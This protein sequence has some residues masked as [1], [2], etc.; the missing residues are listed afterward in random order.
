M[1]ESL[2]EKQNEN[3]IDEKKNILL[4]EFS[5]YGF[6]ENNLISQSELSLILDNK[7]PNNKFDINLLDDLFKF[8]NLNELSI[9]SISKFVSGFFSFQDNFISDKERLNE[10]YLKQKEIFDNLSKM[11][12]KHKEEKINEEG[13]SENGKLSGEIIDINFNIDLNEIKEIILKIKYKD[14][15][16]DII[17]DMNQIIYG[18][19][20]NNKT[21][22]FKASSEKDNIEFILLSKDNSGNNKEIGSQTYSLEGLSS[23]ESIFVQIDIRLSENE[24]NIAAIIKANIA[25]K[26]SEFKYYEN[27]KEKEESKFNNLQLNLEQV[28]EKIKKL[29]YI[30]SNKNGNK[31]EDKNKKD[32][33]NKKEKNN[34]QGISKKIFEFHEN[35]Y[36]IKFN[37]ERICK[38]GIKVTN[39]FT[40]KENEENKVKKPTKEKDI[41]KILE[42]NKEK[43][44][45]NDIKN[46]CNKIDI[47]NN[48]NK[49]D[50]KNSTDKIDIAKD[51]NENITQNYNNEFNYV[52]YYEQPNQDNILNIN[53]YEQNYSSYNNTFLSENNNNNFLIN[54][55]VLPVKYMPPIVNDVIYNTNIGTL[56]QP[57]TDNIF[58]DTNLINTNYDIN[59][60]NLYNY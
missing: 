10:E 52:Q 44:I 17:Q 1:K 4:K 19:E 9:I 58:Y 26:K 45:N 35:K 14:E 50:I 43:N 22:E 40:D 30:Y 59:N 18:N 57:Q 49:T 28:K 5:K 34:E 27:L 31:K 46:N 15:T 24:E 7:S 39:I 38:N 20:N 60:I 54:E 3:E 6:S 37:N 8:L 48:N 47:K 11:C 2:S 25:L 41:K 21:F 42:I 36:I 53:N 55:S 33:I 51:S 23:H 12:D 32:K 13:F 16:K 29:E 56:P